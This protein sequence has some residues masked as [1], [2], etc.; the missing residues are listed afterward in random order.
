[1]TQKEV[2]LNHLKTSSITSMQA[3]KHYGITRLSSVI[4]QLRK[5]G[6]KID[7]KLIPVKNRYGGIA[8]VSR[9]KL[10]GK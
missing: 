7:G 8:Y 4:C 2:I 5:D 6:Y 3:I 9:Y 10:E 1:M